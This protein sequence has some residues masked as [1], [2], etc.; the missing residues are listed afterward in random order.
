[1]L[2]PKQIEK[3]RDFLE[4]AQNPL[5]L[6]DNDVDG[7]AS[8]LLLARFCGK[9]KGVAI[10]SFPDL[11][12]SHARRLYEFK[13]DYVFVLDK[14]L[15]EKGFRDSAREFGVPIIWLDHHPAPDYTNEEGIF[16]FNPLQNKPSN[17]PTSY[18]A[19][20][21]TKRKEDEW[22][23][24][25][26]CLADW[27]IP[28]FDESF[29]KEY[30]DLFI[31][32]KDPAKALYETEIGRIV[33]MLSFALKDRTSIVVKMLKNLLTLK[34][35]REI[36]DITIKTSSIHRRYKQINKKY[37]KI[38]SRARDIARTSKKLL[39][40]QYGG[41]LSLSSELSNELSYFYP[42]RIVVV[43]Y[44][45]GTKANISIRG[46][47]NVRDLIAK[48]LEGIESTSGGHEKASGAS[49]SVED[50]PKFRDKLFELIKK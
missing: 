3:F 5:F 29:S 40:F 8:F 44:I 17:E 25:I 47:I 35:P 50:L 28:E 4:K 26:G 31:L 11:S 10:K 20:K 14:P 23:S 46:N 6:F 38:L 21:I 16:Y 19:Y 39:F 13:P 37:E 15:I 43:A 41:E 49:L 36:L 30:P 18:W 12:V 27:Y 22:I 45:K 9:G 7:L 33:K 2:T 1:M 42:D 24:M 32:T 34:N 48:A